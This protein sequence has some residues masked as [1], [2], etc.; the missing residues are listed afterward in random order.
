MVSADELAGVSLPSCSW[1]KYNPSLS[2]VHFDGSA[3]HVCLGSKS[4]PVLIVDA[5]ILDFA[6]LSPHR[7]S[8]FLA[9]HLAKRYMNQPKDRW[10]MVTEGPFPF[11]VNGDFLM[12]FLDQCSVDG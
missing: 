1:M 11:R 5:I 3:F 10:G 12:H 7:L 4:S 2:S 8:Y 6:G 9:G